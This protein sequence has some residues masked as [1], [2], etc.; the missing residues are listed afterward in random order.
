MRGGRDTIA[1][2]KTIKKSDESTYVIVFSTKKTKF[3][4]VEI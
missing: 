1:H 3:S 2:K 4:L